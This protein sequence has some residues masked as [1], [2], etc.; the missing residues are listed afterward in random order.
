MN[1]VVTFTIFA[2]MRFITIIGYSGA[3]KSYYASMIKGEKDYV[4]SMDCFYKRGQPPESDFDCI[5]AF[6]IDLL[7]RF[8]CD[9]LHTEMYT[10]T[11]NN[12]SLSESR[13]CIPGDT[14][15]IILEGILSIPQQ[16]DNS[17]KVI[18]VI[19]KNSYESRLRRDKKEA[20]NNYILTREEYDILVKGFY[21]MNTYA[22]ANIDNKFV[23]YDNTF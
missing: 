14:E 21:K 22:L 8:L 16:I 10:Y 17:E 3:G 13:I 11:Y 15:C 23:F 6:N 1:I 12:P 18:F 2:T 19:N 5:E 20:R 9:P 7:Q 4:L